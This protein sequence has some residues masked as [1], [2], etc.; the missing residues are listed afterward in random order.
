MAINI[1]SL[2]NTNQVSR[3]LEQQ[4]DLKNQAAQSASN[5]AQTAKVG[6]DSVSLTPQAKQLAE[7]QKKETN[8]PDVNQKKVEKLKEAIQSGAYKVDAEKLAESIAKFEFD[9]I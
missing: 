8:D 1:N 7:M 2:N 3:N 4:A 9:L 6:Q 5:S